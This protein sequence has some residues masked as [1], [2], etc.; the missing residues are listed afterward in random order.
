M[1]NGRVVSSAGELAMVVI[2]GASLTLEQVEE[3]ARK[4][5]QVALAPEA[6][7]RMARRRQGIEERL[8]AG[9]V[10]Y[11]VN[12]GFGRMADVVIPPQRL[13]E[14]QLNLLR[15]HACGVGPPFAS[16][17]VRAMLLLRAN[18][19]ATGFAGVRPEV[20][21]RLLEL[22]N[23][24]VHPV[25]PSQGSVG[26]SGDL[27]P[28]AHLALVLVG[29][30]YAQVGDAVLPGREALA[31]AGLT[32]LTLAPKEGLALINGTQA[33][34][35]VG[36]LALL[37][38][39]RL[40]QAADVVAAMS[41]D[42]L[43]GTDVA[44]LE[45]IHRA[46]PHPGQ[47][48]SARNL[49]GLL[50]GSEIRESHRRCSRVQDA[51]ALRCTPQVHGAAREALAH[52]RGKLAIEVNSATDN[53]M[54]LEDGRVVSGGNFHGAAVAAA[55]DY[56]TIALTDV[57]SIS[58][59]RA[60]RLVTP[61]QSGLPA[62]LVPDPGL[63]SG[64]MM[65]HVTAAA[66]VSECKTLAHPASVDSIPTSAGREDHV[67]MGTWAARK[68]ATVVE[69]LRYV[70]AIELLLAA[71]GIELR[72]PLRSSPALERALGRLRQDVPF[73]AE[74]RFLHAD[75]LKAAALV[76]HLDPGRLLAAPS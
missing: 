64:F 6:R 7:E 51:Y 70:L 68:L 18:V 34:T 38:G 55:F 72:R 15:S 73:L 46:R 60:A 19:L 57:A 50:Q 36:A 65:A 37:D 2:D 58:E 62:F 53:P 29:E 30:G 10:I 32:P 17:V 75:I 49:F 9:E 69:H 56:A 54:V 16:E 48:A 39:E 5:A 63:H 12:T 3:V 23:A 22:L 61:E 31:R 24:G 14:L 28:L 45:E 26:A 66:L 42:A 33:M 40:C 71:Q 27:A 41:V 67:S 13:R 8:A 20:V 43:E 59:R 21:E 52:L 35:A 4:G 25:V 76:P 74:D 11:G 1:E 47:M 44:F